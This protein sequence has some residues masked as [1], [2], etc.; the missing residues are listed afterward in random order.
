MP[1]PEMVD[2]PKSKVTGL[3]FGTR[4]CLAEH[5]R[6]WSRDCVVADGADRFS[7]NVVISCFLYI[8]FSYLLVLIRDLDSPFQYDGQSYMNVDLSLLEVTGGRLQSL[9]SIS[10]VEP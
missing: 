1:F 8:S 10:S 4:L 2:I 6:D 9:S 7:E 5:L 3:G